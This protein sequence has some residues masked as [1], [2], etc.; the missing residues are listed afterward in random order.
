[1]GTT[2]TISVRVLDA[3]ATAPTPVTVISSD[4]MIVTVAGQVIVPAGQQVVDLELATGAG[5]RATLTLEVAGARFEI[6]VVVGSNPGP[7]SP[8]IGAAPVGV[9]VVAAPSLGRII[10]PPNVGSTP[11]IVVPLL[12]AP[13]AASVTVTVTTS[14]A[15]IAGIGTS[16]SVE[17]VIGTGSQVVGL[18]LSIPGTEGVAVL[19]FDFE[20]QRRELVVIVGNPPASQIPAVTSPIVGVEIR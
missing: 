9:S 11:T 3:P 8:T 7:S 13:A 6:G 5:G 14:D 17:L 15:A 10:A 20:G 1:M 12:A 16:A 19:R 18:P 2:R 4:P